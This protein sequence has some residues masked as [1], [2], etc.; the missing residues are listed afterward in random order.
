MVTMTSAEKFIC[1]VYNVADAESCNEACTTLFSRCRSPEALPPMS[2]A[3]RL[4]IRRAHFQAIIWKQAHLTNPTL[5]L[6]ETM[7]WSRLNDKLIPKSMSLTFVPESCDEMVNCGCKSGCNT[8]KC[9]HQNVGLPCTGACKCRSTIDACCQNVLMMTLLKTKGN[10]W[11]S[12]VKLFG[13]F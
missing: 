8:M 4:H 6:P 11:Y 5:P 3:A 12:I 9:S 13:I 10:E 1:R 2:D 7:G